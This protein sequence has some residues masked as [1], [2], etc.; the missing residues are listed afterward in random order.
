MPVHHLWESHG[1]SLPDLVEIQKFLE[2]YGRRKANFEEM[3]KNH[4]NCGTDYRVLQRWFQG[5]AADG[6][7][8]PEIYQ[9]WLRDGELEYVFV[10]H[11]CKIPQD[12]NLDILKLNLV[13]CSFHPKPFFEA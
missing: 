6:D 10:F 11:E 7:F 9:S 4:I 12:A 2:P 3:P 8:F 13:G 1:S 5:A